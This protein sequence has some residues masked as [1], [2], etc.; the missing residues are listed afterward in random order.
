[1]TDTDEV[2]LGN[3]DPRSSKMNLY[4]EAHGKRRRIDRIDQT[5]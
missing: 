5:D 4:D 2:E 3:I 1:M